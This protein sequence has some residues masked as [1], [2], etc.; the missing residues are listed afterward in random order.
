MDGA[1]RDGSAAIERAAQLE[2]ENRQLQEEV[3]RMRAELDTSVNRD[4]YVKR[5]QE[6]RDELRAKVQELEREAASRDKELAS[7]R[8]LVRQ[9]TATGNLKEALTPLA[10]FLE[11]I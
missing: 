2:A 10:K 6:E 8:R 4:A 1:F 9:E 5:L 7:L 11:W 3:E